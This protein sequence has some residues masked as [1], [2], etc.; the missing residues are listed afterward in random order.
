MFSH[1]YYVFFI[2]TTIKQIIVSFLFNIFP[3]YYFFNFKL[4]LICFLKFFSTKRSNN[5]PPWRSLIIIV[6]DTVF[7]A[8]LITKS[9]FRQTWMVTFCKNVF[10]FWY[11]NHITNFKFR[12]FIINSF[13]RVNI[14]DC[15]YI[16]SFYFN[17][18]MLCIII[19]LNYVIEFI[20]IHIFWN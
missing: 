15:F 5:S 16:N 18:T 13:T 9:L 7:L 19:F 3:L 11:S 12:I 6:H 1:L 4:F 20:N 14:C 17:C 10:I 8:F 2:D